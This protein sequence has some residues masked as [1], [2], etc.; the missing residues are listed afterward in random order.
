MIITISQFM[1]HIQKYKKPEPERYHTT[2]IGEKLACSFQ[3]LKSQAS[4]TTV[5]LSY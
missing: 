2:N 5:I 3:H 4:N 1:L